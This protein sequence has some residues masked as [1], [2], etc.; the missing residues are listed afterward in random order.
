M[1]VGLVFHKDPFAPPT[2]ID[3]VR[4]RSLA[5]GMIARGLDVT[6]LSPC[7][8]QGLLDGMIPVRDTEVLS[9][10]ERFDVVKTCYHPSIE[11]VAPYTGPIVSRIVRVVDERLPERDGRDR[12]R[13]LSQQELISRRAAR[14]ALNNQVNVDRWNALY[15]GKPPAI[16]VPT[17]CPAV[18]PSLGLNPFPWGEKAVLF[19]GSVAGAQMLDMLN[20]AAASL[21]GRARIHLVGLN[22]AEMYGAK[23]S[24]ALHPAIVHHSEI[25]EWE[26]WDFIRHASVGL[27]L[28][29]SPHEFDN[30]ISKMYNYLRGGLPV[31]SEERIVNN[32]LVRTTGRGL[33]FRYGDV[34]DLREKALSLINDPPRGDRAAVSGFMASEHSWDR[35]VENYVN[36]F[37]ELTGC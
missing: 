4:L 5:R 19:L 1:K 32:D 28:A 29:A 21:E 2:G 13:L 24:C 26:T 33:I 12:E 7:A 23:G 10:R 9:Q 36:L 8:A 3:L 20:R 16:I 14:V 25:A 37:R 18:I 35:R 27:A 34:N 11:L 6:I 15:G 17:G 31:L 22:K 30:D